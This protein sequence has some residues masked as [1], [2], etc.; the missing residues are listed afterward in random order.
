MG[1][2][3]LSVDFWVYVPNKTLYVTTKEERV[4]GSEPVV[5]KIETELF[6]FDYMRSTKSFDPCEVLFKFIFTLVK[7]LQNNFFFVSTKYK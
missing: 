3:W 1:R 4:G 6:S 7:G 2:Y 5:K